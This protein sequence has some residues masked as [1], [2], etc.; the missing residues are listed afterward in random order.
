[1]LG[2]V[3]IKTERDADQDCLLQRIPDSAKNQKAHPEKSVLVNGSMSSGTADKCR[4]W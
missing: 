1:M 3:D 4:V 2:Y